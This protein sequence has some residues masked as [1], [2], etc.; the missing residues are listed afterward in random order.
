MYT[1]TLI[2]DLMATVEAAERGAL[3]KK[4]AEEMELQ[5]MFELQVQF[6]QVQH[7]RIFAGA[8]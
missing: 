1:G 6:S 8:A 3:R 7:E 4:Q 5:R 2:Q